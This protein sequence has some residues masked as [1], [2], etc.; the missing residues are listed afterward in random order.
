MFIRDYYIF[1]IQDSV[2]DSINIVFGKHCPN[3]F[4]YFI[5][6]FSEDFEVFIKVLFIVSSTLNLSLLLRHRLD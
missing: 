5:S 6:R 4:T 3:V 2:V 1:I